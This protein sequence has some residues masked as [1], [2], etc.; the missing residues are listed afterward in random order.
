[1]FY[2]PEKRQNELN[3]KY[4]LTKEDILMFTNIFYDTKFII[5]L[6][7]LP[8]SQRFIE[9]PKPVLIDYGQRNETVND[10]AIEKIR[11]YFK[12]LQ[13]CIIAIWMNDYSI[14]NSTDKTKRLSQLFEKWRIKNWD[15]QT[16][17]SIIPTWFQKNTFFWKLKQKIFWIKWYEIKR[18]WVKFFLNDM[19]DEE[20]EVFM[21]N[22]DYGI[23]ISMKMFDMWDFL[24]RLLE[25][26]ENFQIKNH[27]SFQAEE[28][29]EYIAEQ[30]D[31][32]RNHPWD[33]TISIPLKE[34]MDNK[35]FYYDIL[36]QLH[37][38]EYL[39]F[40]EVY[41]LQQNITFIIHKVH[42]FERNILNSLFPIYE[43]IRFEWWKLFLDSQVLVTW[44]KKG[45]K[46][47]ELIDLI[48]RWIKCF[49]KL[50]IQYSELSD[51]FIEKP[52][53]F[54]YIYKSLN[55]KQVFEKILSKIQNSQNDSDIKIF[56][57]EL[58]S[59]LLKVFCLSFFNSSLVVLSNEKIKFILKDATTWIEF[60]AN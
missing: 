16:R 27:K 9:I 48:V 29:F 14:Y 12:L 28:L 2:T 45:N 11:L 7:A 58:E 21:G 20:M 56:R 31:W 60:N 4:P 13:R 24:P 30:I 43:R 54:P 18:P 8:P 46:N 5:F 19:L 50:E 34:Y 23:D 37:I 49:E 22:L 44:K 38:K 6:K 53:D 3:E 26:I 42:S 25:H 1:M 36:Y 15:P 47:Y 17:V 10:F 52:N 59:H 57:K 51:I 35:N 40:K 55:K 39:T 41:L 32:K 33:I